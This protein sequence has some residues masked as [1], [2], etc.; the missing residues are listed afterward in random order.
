[1][2]PQNLQVELTHYFSQCPGDTGINITSCRLSGP[3]PRTPRNAIIL[4]VPRHLR[5]GNR[6][7]GSFPRAPKTSSSEKDMARA[8]W[9][10]FTK[11]KQNLS[12]EL[13]AALTTQKGKALPHLTC[14]DPTDKNDAKW[15]LN[16]TANMFVC[17]PSFFT[18]VDAYTCLLEA[19]VP[20]P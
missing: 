4:L 6:H 18:C 9:T 14:P 2:A 13:W 12:R 3:Y 16:G 8:R 19:T 11:A 10:D 20:K 15:K 17:G 5:R 7:W 1:M